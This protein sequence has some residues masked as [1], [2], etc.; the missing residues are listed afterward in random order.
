MQ[1]ISAAR[2]RGRNKILKFGK[3]RILS[4]SKKQGATRFDKLPLAVGDSTE[5]RHVAECKQQPQAV[6]VAVSERESEWQDLRSEKMRVSKI[7][8]LS[9]RA[10]MIKVRVQ[11]RGTPK[12]LLIVARRNLATAVKFVRI[13]GN[14]KI[15][16]NLQKHNTA[17]VVRN[18]KWPQVRNSCNG[19]RRPRDST[20]KSIQEPAAFS[21]RGEAVKCVEGN[22]EREDGKI[23]KTIRLREVI[24]AKCKSGE[25][26]G[27]SGQHKCERGEII[28][29]LDVTESVRNVCVPQKLPGEVTIDYACM[30]GLRRAKNFEV[31]KLAV[32][33]T[34]KSLLL[35]CETHKLSAPLEAQAHFQTPTL[36]QC[37]YPART[38]F[39]SNTHLQSVIQQHLLINAPD[40]LPFCHQIQ[41]H[42]EYDAALED[43]R[44]TSQQTPVHSP[45]QPITRSQIYFKTQ[46]SSNSYQTLAPLTTNSSGIQQASDFTTAKPEFAPQNHFKSQPFFPAQSQLFSELKRIQ[47]TSTQSN[48]YQQRTFERTESDKHPNHSIQEYFTSAVKNLSSTFS[49]SRQLV[50]Q[51][52]PS[53]Y[54]Q[55]SDVHTECLFQSQTCLRQNTPAHGRNKDH[56]EEHIPLH[57][58]VPCSSFNTSQLSNNFNAAPLRHNWCSWLFRSTPASSLPGGRCCRAPPSEAL[59]FAASSS[60]LH[61]PYLWRGLV[62]KKLFVSTLLLLLT[63]L[64]LTCAACR[65][66]PARPCEAIC[67]PDGHNCTLRALLLLPD[68]D[69]YIASMR[70]TMP[71]MYLAEQYLRKNSLLPPQ[72]HF[73]WMTGDVKCEAAYATIKAMDGIA[74]NCAHVVFG[75]VCDYALAAVS[76]IAKYFSSNGT[77]VISVGGATD[78]FEFPKT[79]CA[80]EFYMLL[81]A[82]LLSFKSISVMIIELLKH[83]NW[84]NSIVFYER[85]GRKDVAGEHSCY[86]MMKSFGDE[87]RDLNLTF[88]QYSLMPELHNRTEEV[89]REIGNKHTSK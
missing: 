43:Q 2:R 53:S 71:V 51:S 50:S 74:R 42:N 63:A 46:S 86:L 75:P 10:E 54:E 8:K 65:D 38:Q 7:N 16:R 67:T 11:R 59:P 28:K 18:T 79:S 70:S 30:D 72:L 64:P 49:T 17:I 21:S 23:I 57:K 77:P 81:R 60:H 88:A 85:D 89:K 5:K 26:K 6:R 36:L 61:L 4:G 52:D 55:Q 27:N 58:Q 13:V 87:M 78:S 62:R 47:Q 33:Q 73:E 83:Y 68:D 41:A 19:S 76:R 84:T 66:E 69:T 29:V 40:L 12:S 32:E 20:S 34:S 15:I 80:D 9:K 31:P 35:S 3:H 44:Q 45:N 14:V 24:E 1:T 39:R 25:D 22:F 37:E 48:Q 82:G 56:S